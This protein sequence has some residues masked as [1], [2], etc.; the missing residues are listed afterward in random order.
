M[1]AAADYAAAKLALASH[2]PAYVSYTATT[3]AKFDA[4]GHDDKKQV[5]VRTSDGTVLKGATAP[6]PSYVQIGSEQSSADEPVAKPAFK[7]DCYAAAD[8]RAATFEGRTL[9]AIALRDT[10]GKKK[11]DKDFDTL[12]VDPATHR[13]VIATGSENDQ[14]VAVRLEQRFAATGNYVMP[15]SLYV[16]VQGSGLMSWLDVLYDR[17]YDDYRFSAT[18][19]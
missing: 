4:I 5:V 3:H 10:C 18:E 8:A 9:E 1:D 13:P 17:R 7:P 19:P 11:G 2:L 6:Q 12:Y 14:G 16:R 15:S